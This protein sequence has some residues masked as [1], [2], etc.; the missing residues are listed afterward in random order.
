MADFNNDGYPDLIWVNLNGPTL[1][2]I[3]TGGKAHYLKVQLKDDPHSLG[4]LVTLVAASGK[5][6]VSHFIQGEGLASD[7]THVLTF[8]LGAESGVRTVTVK[9]LTGETKSVSGPPMDSTLRI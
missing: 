5:Q 1:A 8:G 4:A 9:Y 2:F 6:F 7:Q 3:N